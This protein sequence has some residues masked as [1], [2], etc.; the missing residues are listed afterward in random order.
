M[1]VEVGVEVQ[2]GVKVGLEEDVEGVLELGDCA[3]FVT[4]PSPKD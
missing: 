3:E 1:G 4:G 2:V